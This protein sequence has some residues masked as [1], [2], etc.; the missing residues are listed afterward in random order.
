M[1]VDI[2]EGGSGQQ[3]WLFGLE[4]GIVVSVVISCRA[5]VRAWAMAMG[6]AMGGWRPGCGREYPGL[7]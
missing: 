7:A 6:V 1:E 4:P 5:R 2:G 3:L